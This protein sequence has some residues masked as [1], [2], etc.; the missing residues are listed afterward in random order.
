MTE[1]VDLSSLLEETEDSL[2]LLARVAQGSICVEVHDGKGLWG[3]D[4]AAPTEA[5]TV[6][7]PF[8]IEAEPVG[9]IKVRG[10]LGRDVGELAA[11][12]LYGVYRRRLVVDVYRETMTDNYEELVERNQR[13]AN[14]A[15]SLEEQV[16][17]RTRELDET[18]ARL[19]REEKVAAIGRLSAGIAHELNTPLACVRS[20]LGRLLEWLPLDGESSEIVRESLEMADRAAG[21]V[22]DLRGFSHVDDVGLVEVDLN[23]EVDR[24]L[25]RLEVPTGVLIE[26][27]Y[28]VLERVQVDGRRLTVALLHLFENARDAV[29]TGGRIEITTAMEDGQA[30]VFVSDDGPGIPP[31]IM[32]HVFDPFFTTKEVGKGTGL[33]LTVAQNIARAHGGDLTLEC[34]EGRGTVARLAIPCVASECE[35]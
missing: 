19:A 24:I 14:L 16:R 35:R 22:R 15:A 30:V 10:A 28:G 6:E 29:A 5:H 7:V 27:N 11:A 26:K 34:R 17:V 25:M 18:H 3:V 8:R 31:E 13:L 12:I 21:I 2:R 32:R 33:G 23:E 4:E 1:T 20:N 9:T